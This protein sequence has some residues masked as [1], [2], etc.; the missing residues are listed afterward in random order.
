MKLERGD[1]MKKQTMGSLIAEIRKEKGMTQK[2][3]AD[4]LNITDRAISKWERDICCPDISIL[5]DLSNI[6]DI[7][8]SQLISGNRETK[9][10]NEQQIINYTKMS[11]RDKIIN[12]L[13]YI[14]LIIPIII[15]IFLLISNFII[16]R[17]FQ[18]TYK[19]IYYDSEHVELITSVNEKMNLILNIHGKYSDE[20]YEKIENRINLLQNILPIKD[21]EKI[22]STNKYN[23]D[24]IIAYLNINNDSS[25]VLQMS[26]D[27]KIY[28]MIAKYDLGVI[29]NIADNSMLYDLYSDYK[30]YLDHFKAH[31]GFYNYHFSKGDV[32][33]NLYSLVQI[34]YSFY[35]KL[36]DDIIKAGDING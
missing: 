12:I 22:L 36:L 25:M 3:L 18:D 6:L 21:D 35:D 29:D 19:N 4:K 15:L 16:T 26:S 20:D 27:L 23:Y 17:N 33:Y 7:S 9:K 14:L 10:I 34:K 31:V 13:N 32:A 8:I 28:N 24:E 1:L 5:E 11:I 2:D 30:M